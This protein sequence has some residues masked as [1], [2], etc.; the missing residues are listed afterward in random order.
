MDAHLGSFGGR[1]WYRGRS[2]FEYWQ[3]TQPIFDVV[4]RRGAAFCVE[5]GLG[6]GFLPR[7]RFFTDAE[8]A[9]QVAFG[10]VT[11]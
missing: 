10:V 8:W 11:Q 1:P 7:S 5:R 3:N 6:K 9:E 2:K 4:D